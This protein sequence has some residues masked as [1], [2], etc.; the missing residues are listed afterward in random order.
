MMSTGT[1][2]P[3]ITPRAVHS[4]SVP[5]LIL[6]GARSYPFLAVIDRVLA[7]FL[8]HSQT[9]TFP[10]AGHQMWLQEPEECRRDVEK[11]LEEPRIR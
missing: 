11:F 5:V 6:G 8:P 7:G 9:I 2:F 10:N 4:I 1:L 3:T